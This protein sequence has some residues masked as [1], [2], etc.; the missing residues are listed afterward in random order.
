MTEEKLE[1]RQSISPETAV[2][3]ERK[4]EEA[5]SFRWLASF[6]TA[7]M[8]FLLGG[9]E[10]PLS[11]QPFGCAL[12]AALPKHT[13]AALIGIILRSVVSSALGGEMLVSVICATALLVCRI[14]LNIIVF[15]QHNIE[16]LKRLPD[17][18]VTKLLL[19]ALFVFGISF[20]DALSLGIS[21]LGV[22]HAGLSALV[23]VG[24][25]LLFAFFF[26]EEY[27]HAP[28]F[29]AGLGALVYALSL[30]LMPFHIGS[31]SLG[32]AA[33][34][35][36]TVFIGFL[37]VPT[38]SASVG[39]L[40]GLASGGIFAPVLSLAGLVTGIFSEHYAIFGGISAALVTVCTALYFGGT[41]E[42]LSF[43]PELC[44]SVSS[45]T[46]LAML[47][48]LPKYHFP[49]YTKDKENTALAVWSKRRETERELQMR[50]LSG[51][52]DSLSSLVQGFSERFRRP[53]PEK[54]T[55][56][57]RTVWK[58]Y[59][60]KC[61]NE[62]S[63]R[64]LEGLESEKITAKL[65]SRLMN[66]GRIDR[67]RLYE[68]TR[69]RC[70]HLDAIAAEISALSARM[71]EEAIREDKTRVFALDYGIMSQ[72]FAD[73]AAESDMR[74]PVDKV[75]SERLRRAFRR[76]GLR[77]E[78][79]L[80]CGDRKKTVIATGDALVK[81][82]L[83]PSDIRLICEGSC[84]VRFETPVFMLEAGRSAC[85]LESR[86]LYTVETVM[87]QLPKKGEYVC[88]DNI[89]V[90]ISGDDRFYCYL[91]D[92]MGSGEEAALT[93]RL[94]GVFL[95]KMLV[96]GNKKSTTLDMLNHLLCSRNTECFATVDICEI[97]LVT[98]VASFLKCGAVPSF[99]MRGG[100]LYKISAGTFPIGI[101]PQVSAETTDFEL[102]AG[103]VVVLCSDGIISDPDAAD[104][105]DAVRFLDI[106]TREWTDDLTAMAEKILA[107]SSDFSM[108]SDDMT[109]AL[110]RLKKAE[111][112]FT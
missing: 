26:D 112:I 29:E 73:A 38:R 80:V 46:A 39:L 108:R 79:V 59:C 65:A 107:Y 55:E 106:I 35:A 30:S 67:E 75:L 77:A 83:R 12:V 96:C 102:C 100:R 49:E 86:P 50:G 91:C 42:V 60:E 6:L 15:G 51:A 37:G 64:G 11:L 98:G 24:F 111:G 2:P 97:D 43:L 69:V 25:T 76:A 9:T 7:G 58:K 71:L 45:V 48:L 61:P 95:E 101:L 72:M 105:E 92:G 62:C 63:C 40:C 103:D 31:F 90:S 21:I 23:S 22:L 85:V 16:R 74:M 8:G 3:K 18:L 52:L 14:V 68:I 27:R 32:L 28:V 41:E 10:L 36:A 47:R 54:L 93:S 19:C 81:T 110:L 66:A 1:Q 78:N 99:V 89:S 88:G 13:V 94:C 109:V 17:S 5:V 70:P 56:R 87:K 82:E 53:A 33:A 84:G 20:V 104:G 57:C 4:R 34:F 44:V